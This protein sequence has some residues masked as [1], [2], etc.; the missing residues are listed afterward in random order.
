MAEGHQWVFQS[1]GGLPPAT[2]AARG[3]GG[4]P[5]SE[6]TDGRQIL[7]DAEVP[8]DFACFV[9]GRSS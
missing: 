7:L 3:I 2:H 4:C 8:D 1:L 6:P 9:G 5:N